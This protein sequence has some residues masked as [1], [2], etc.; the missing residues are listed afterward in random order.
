MKEDTAEPSSTYR[1]SPTG[2]LFILCVAQTVRSRYGSWG[3][4][5]VGIRC[6]ASELHGYFLS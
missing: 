5:F 1:T 4:P 2:C 3:I 6:V